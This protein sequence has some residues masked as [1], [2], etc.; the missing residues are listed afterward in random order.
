MAKRDL[1]EADTVTLAVAKV[2]FAPRPRV[3][4]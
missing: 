4:V 2:V 1:E 3:P